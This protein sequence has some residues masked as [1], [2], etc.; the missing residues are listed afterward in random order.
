MITDYDINGLA[1]YN[2]LFIAVGTDTL[3][4]SLGDKKMQFIIYYL[5][6]W[7]SNLKLRCCIWLQVTYTHYYLQ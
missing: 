5:V 1:N 7:A 2:V 6:S 3:I 4:S